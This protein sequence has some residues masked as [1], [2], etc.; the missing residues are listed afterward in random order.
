LLLQG[1]R[2]VA[3]GCFLAALAAHALLNSVGVI[4]GEWLLNGLLAGPGPFGP[5]AIP[6]VVAAWLAALGAFLVA[7]GWAAVLFVYF[8][9]LEERRPSWRVAS[10]A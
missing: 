9:R 5:G 6:L 1:R 10:G 7:E 4:L 8:L 3:I 2:G